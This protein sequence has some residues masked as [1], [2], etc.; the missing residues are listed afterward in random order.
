MTVWTE[1]EIVE[2]ELYRRAEY[3]KNELAKAT[4][5]YNVWFNNNTMTWGD[6]VAIISANVKHFRDK[7]LIAI[8]N[9]TQFPTVEKLD[10][11][12]RAWIEGIY[13]QINENLPKWSDPIRQTYNDI[14]DTAKD[15]AKDVTTWG[16]GGIGLGL[17]LVGAAYLLL[18]KRW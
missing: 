6:G 14:R 4:I 13:L 7:A 10:N 2:G 9:P 5:A 16:A 11:A 17:V 12:V 18:N 8:Q 3:W 1:K 15:V